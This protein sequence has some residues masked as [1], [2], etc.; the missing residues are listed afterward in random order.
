MFADEGSDP[1][2]FAAAEAS[3]NEVVWA[4]GS[5]GDAD[6]NYQFVYNAAS[7]QVQIIKIEVGSNPAS[8][9]EATRRVVLWAN[10]VG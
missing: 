10:R 5:V 6:G 2:V 7:Q 1:N 9:Q 8:S 4:S 3:T